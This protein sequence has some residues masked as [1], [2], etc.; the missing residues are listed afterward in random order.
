M[1]GAS[2]HELLE[3]AREAPANVDSMM[4]VGHNE[5]ITEFANL[6]SPKHI[7]SMPTAGVVALRFD[8]ENW[9]DIK[10]D[11]AELLFY[12]VPKNHK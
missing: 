7:A 12:D 6:I 3:I 1:Y 9:H 5:P 11:N 4:M 10:R 8:C 2:A